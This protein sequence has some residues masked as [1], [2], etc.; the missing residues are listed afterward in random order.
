[1]YFLCSC[2]TCRMLHPTNIKP[3]LS[4]ASHIRSIH[5]WK[6]VAACGSCCILTQPGWAEW[7]TLAIYG[8]PLPV[9]GR[10]LPA[11][12]CLRLSLLM[13]AVKQAPRHL[14][15]GPFLGW[16]IWVY[17]RWW[18]CMA[19]WNYQR[20]QRGTTWYNMFSG[21]RK[22]WCPVP[23]TACSLRL[24]WHVWFRVDVEVSWCPRYIDTSVWKWNMARNT[25]IKWH[26]YGQPNHWNRWILD[27]YG[28][29]GFFQLTCI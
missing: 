13:L 24:K 25:D 6:G 16:F 1:M 7:R 22:E 27:I 19:M 2:T 29:L 8:N 20:V 3:V 10:V 4:D 17:Q 12:R 9:Q 28:Y 5:R 21:A 23:K 14:E 26:R 15:I 18:L 11:R